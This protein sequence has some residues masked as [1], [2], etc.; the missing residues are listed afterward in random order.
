[1][2]KVQIDLKGE[3][4]GGAKTKTLGTLMGRQLVASGWDSW[5]ELHDYWRRCWWLRAQRIKGSG[6]WRSTDRG[7]RVC[8]FIW[9]VIENR[10]V[11]LDRGDKKSGSKPHDH[12]CNRCQK[13]RQR[14]PKTASYVPETRVSPLPCCLAWLSAL[15]WVTSPHPRNWRRAIFLWSLIWLG[16]HPSDESINNALPGISDLAPA[17]RI[18]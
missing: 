5:K 12:M 10:M 14:L 18:Y 17:Y 3:K 6:Y 13:R 1:M 8:L 11:N 4:K 7:G 2:P 15:R 16:L 9:G